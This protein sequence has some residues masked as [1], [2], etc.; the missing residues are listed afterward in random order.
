MAMH[1]EPTITAILNFWFGDSGT[2]STSYEQR[3]RFWF[4]KTPEFDQAIREQ[5]HAVYAQAAAGQ[6]DHWQ[7]TPEGS[8]AL[9]LVLDQFS[10]NMFRDTAQA[11]ATDP[12]A[13]A[14]AKR[15]I[16]RGFDQQ[17]LP[18]QRIFLYLPL[19]HSE[20]LADQQ[21]SVEQFR[22]LIAASPDLQDT[23]DYALRHQSVIERFG[24]FPHRNRL[25][26]RDTTPE[27]AE[28]L[29][30]PGSSF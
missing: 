24:R 30:Q 18:I 5:F 25:L 22:Q 12:Q 11:F 10:R 4:G 20:D 19:E 8:L 21:Q 26:G 17:L 27:E 2:E 23:F 9:I 13:L 28:F 1:S 6:L 14:A 3:R 7:D 29:T 16:A 15:A